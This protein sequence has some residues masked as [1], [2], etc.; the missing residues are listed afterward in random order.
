MQIQAEELAKRVAE[1]VNNRERI[2]K[3]YK[4][5]FGRDALESEVALGLEYLKSEPLTGY[6]ERKKK[7]PEPAGGAGPRMRPGGPPPP[8]EVSSNAGDVTAKPMPT[9]LADAAEQGDQA[10]VVAAGIP[11][12]NPAAAAALGDGAMG[13]GMMGGF[14]AGRRGPGAG[15]A[16][17]KYEATVWGRYAKVL[18]SS[19]EF[20][21]IN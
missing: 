10:P 19:S 11:D 7:V 15:P 20:L 17:V 9:E 3:A 21:F 14:G 5:V 13:M 4:L 16:P 18:L 6:E 1:G 2:R 8:V 12:A